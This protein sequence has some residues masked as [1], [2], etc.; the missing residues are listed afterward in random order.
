MLVEEPQIRD[1]AIFATQLLP[2]WTVQ[3]TRRFE[4]MHASV[5]LRWDD[6]TA[7]L[8]LPCIAL[9]CMAI[10]LHS[11]YILQARR[12]IGW[13]NEGSHAPGSTRHV[14]GGRR[15]RRRGAMRCIPSHPMCC[16]TPGP[17]T[18]PGGDGN[19]IIVVDSRQWPLPSPNPVA[20]WRH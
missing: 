5:N 6:R 17:G 10:D 16:R 12:P 15:R 2:R 4:S 3:C 14:P 20:A 7:C 9:H 13:T 8:P 19:H 1:S 11:R 18:R